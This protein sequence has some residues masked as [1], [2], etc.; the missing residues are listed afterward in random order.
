MSK[1]PELPE[2]TIKPK[3][4]RGAS[5]Y[6]ALLAIVISLVGTCVSIFEARILREQQTIMSDEK[7]ATVWPYVSAGANISQEGKS[8]T[9]TMSLKNEGVGPALI[10][11][12]HHVVEGQTGTLTEVLPMLRKQFPA[13]KIIPLLISNTGKKVLGAGESVTAY[14]LLIS[15]QTDQVLDHIEVTG[16]IETEFCYCSIYGDCWSSDGER[17]AETQPCGGRDYLR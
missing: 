14:R 7:E 8:T 15:G 11:D 1:Q 13:F 6:M 4:T 17:L 9:V 16:A 2:Q 5:F 12:L 10:G 3:P